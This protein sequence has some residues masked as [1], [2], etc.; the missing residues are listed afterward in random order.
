MAGLVEDI[1]LWE[2]SKD[3]TCRKPA[4]AEITLGDSVARG[5]VPVCSEHKAEH[6]R[7]AAKRRADARRSSAKTR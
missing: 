6:N 3:E 4:V 7:L 2:V 1:C 5:K